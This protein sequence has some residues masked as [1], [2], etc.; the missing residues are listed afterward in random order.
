MS[1][2]ALKVTISVLV[3]HKPAMK[4]IKYIIKRVFLTKPLISNHIISSSLNNLEHR[5]LL[6][7]MTIISLQYLLP[8]YIDR[9]R[10]ILL[11]A[12][13]K[14]TI[15]SSARLDILHVFDHTDNRVFRSITVQGAIEGWLGSQSRCE[16]RPSISWESL[17]KTDRSSLIYPSR[18]FIF[19]A[20]TLPASTHQYDAGSWFNSSS[21]LPTSENLGRIF[22]PHKLKSPVVESKARK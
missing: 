13:E 16:D 22:R 20:M 12:F 2:I 19:V 7:Y 10:Q 4:L 6:L 3:I 18:S 15:Y 11:L 8:R 17:V 21:T 9:R 1:P 14:V 5:I